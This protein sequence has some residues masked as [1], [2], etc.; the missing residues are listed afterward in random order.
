MPATP[1]VSMCA[2]SNRE[3][4]PPDPCAVAITFGRLLAA[5]SVSTSSPA[6]LHQSATK[7]ASSVSPAA[8]WTRSGLMESIATRSA[9]SFATSPAISG[10]YEARDDRELCRLAFSGG[11]LASRPRRRH[12]PAGR[13]ARTLGGDRP[14]R[15]SHPRLHSRRPRCAV[16]VGTACGVHAGGEG[17]PT[18]GKHALH[19]WHA[20]VAREDRRRGCRAR[21]PGEGGR[22]GD[23]GP[24]Q[25]A[26]ARGV[27]RYLQ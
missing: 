23:P 17:Q 16:V 8:P 25:P 18:G 13:R 24:D 14:P 11:D 21:D 19:V 2:L 4:P 10:V 22:D 5:S 27:N 1:T 3:R 15:P 9:R 6:R 7:C 26:R 12:G 20:F